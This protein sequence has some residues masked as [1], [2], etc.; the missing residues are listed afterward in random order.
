[1]LNAQSSDDAVAT[2]FAEA[3]VGSV[4][5]VYRRFGDAFGWTCVVVVAVLAIR[6]VHFRLREDNQQSVGEGSHP[7]DKDDAAFRRCIV[8]VNILQ[9]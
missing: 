2:L 4:P 9:P 6:V 7:S 8:G 5:T 1:L 3:P